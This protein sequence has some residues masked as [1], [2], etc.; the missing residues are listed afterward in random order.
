MCPTE[1]RKAR[2]HDDDGENGENGQNDENDQSGENG[3][4]SRTWL[5]GK[6]SVT[7]QVTSFYIIEVRTLP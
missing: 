7:V 4:K 5:H 3:R 6:V 1:A 2:R